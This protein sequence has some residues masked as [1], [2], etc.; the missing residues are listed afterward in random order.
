MLTTSPVENQY[1]KYKVSKLNNGEELNFVLRTMIPKNLKN[2]DVVFVCI[3]TDRSTGDSLGPFVG[4]YLK[5]LGYENIYGTI[6][7]PVHAMNLHNILE[8]IPKN[9]TII[10]VDASLGST[11]DIGKLSAC[12]GGL[13]P[14]T[15]VNRDLGVVGDYGIYG[16]VNVSGF[17]EYFALNNTRLSVVLKMVKSIVFAIYNIFPLFEENNNIIHGFDSD[18]KI[19]N[20]LLEKGYEI[21]LLKDNLMKLDFNNERNKI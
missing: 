2:D 15:G 6:D 14:G 5:E 11:T 7:D 1:N 19:Y 3:G 8:T 21:K 13:R 18:E 4:M 20:F 10:A 9:K 16:C 12:K 17:Y